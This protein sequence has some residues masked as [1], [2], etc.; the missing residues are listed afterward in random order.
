MTTMTTEQDT[1]K[2]V[3]C[4]CTHHAKT[5]IFGNSKE[6]DAGGDY[7]A[8]ELCKYQENLG[9]CS[10]WQRSN[11]SLSLSEYPLCVFQTTLV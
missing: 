10:R 3:S 7:D 4:N 9:E 6:G 8:R 2:C 5:D 11:L 1:M